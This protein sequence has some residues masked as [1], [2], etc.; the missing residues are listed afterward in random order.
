MPAFF[1]WRYDEAVMRGILTLLLIPVPLYSQT[2][3]S[4]F[5]NLSHQAE[6]SR[7]AGEMDKAVALYR[8]ALKIKPDWEEGWWSLGSIAYD[9][10]HFSECAPAFRSLAKLKPDS[11]PAWTMAGLCEYKL[12]RFDSAIESLSRAEALKFAEP[13]ELARAARLHLAL[14]LTKS[15]FFER[16][17]AVLT[18]LTRVHN[19][20][21]EILV[22]AGIAGLRQSWLPSEVPEPKRDLVYKLGDA[23]GAAM[24]M[25]F[26]AAIEKFQ[27]VA[28]QYPAEA[29]VHFRYGAF[30]STKDSGAGVA[31]IK[32]AL[33]LAPD[34]IPAMVGLAVIFLKREEFDSALEYAERAVKASPGDFSTHVA[35]GRVYLAKDDPAH[36]AEQLEAAVR[37]APA[38]PEAHFSLAS[39]YSRLGRKEESTRELTDFKRLQHL[40]NR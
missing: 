35:L 21:P 40:D 12:R 13:P 33:E 7:D 3:G 24:E 37:L 17:I 27:A 32:K 31:E 10:D 29:N 5:Q 16:A 34:H 18:E 25:N 39:A 38:S 15:E 9:R 8:N 19:S 2:A 4:S 22:A 20:A 11:A 30:L 28:E 1:V 36:A 6:V 14:A 26:K 23:M